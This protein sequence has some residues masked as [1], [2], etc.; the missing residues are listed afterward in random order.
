MLGLFPVAV[1]GVIDNV[2]AMLLGSTVGRA[3]TVNWLLLAPINA[4]RSSYSPLIVLAMIVGVVLLTM[5]IVHRYYH[6]RVRV[7]PPCWST[8]S[9]T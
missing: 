7:A 3:A 1:I 4:D 9:P 5:Q 6:G 8:R 2:N